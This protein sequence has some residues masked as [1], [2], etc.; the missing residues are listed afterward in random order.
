MINALFFVYS[1]FVL[2]PLMVAVTL[3]FALVCLVT[4]PFLGPRRVARITAVPWARLGLLFSGVPVNVHGRDNLKPG[5]SYVIVANH[6]SQFDIL[7]LYGYLDVDF[8]WVM[9]QELRRVPVI[10]YCCARLGHVFVDRGDREK[11]ITSLEQAKGRLV[12]GTGIL[13]FPE[14]TRSRT[15]ALQ[16]FKKGAFRM[17]QDLNLPILP[18]TLSGTREILPPDSLR[19]HPGPVSLILHPEVVVPGDDEAALEQALKRCRAAIARVEEPG[20]L[21]AT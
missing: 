3:F 19:M 2:A 12:D 1:W 8:R 4:L 14:G 6:L 16:P 18:V 7:V 5:R 21:K 10:G 13:F 11:A 15:G 17:A 20:C 9:K